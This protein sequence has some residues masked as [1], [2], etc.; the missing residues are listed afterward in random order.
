MSDNRVAK[1]YGSMSRRPP[2][3]STALLRIRCNCLKSLVI[4]ESV[5][6][7]SVGGTCSVLDLGC[8]KGGDLSK[9][10]KLRNVTR[11]LGVDVS[12]D[13]VEEANRRLRRRSRSVQRAF[14]FE[15]CDLNVPGEGNSRSVNPFC[16][17]GRRYDLVVCNFAVHYFFSATLFQQVASVLHKN[18]LFVFIKI[19]ADRLRKICSKLGTRGVFQT[20]VVRIEAKQS[21]YDFFLKGSVNCTEPYV[22][23]T[24][25]DRFCRASRL[26]RVRTETFD[27]IWSRLVE[28]NSDPSPQLSWLRNY[29]R[30]CDEITA[31][32]SSP[33]AKIQADVFSLY[34]VVTLTKPS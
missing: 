16:E 28:R 32:I 24:D 34:D 18:G 22:E 4:S 17:R 27:D 8:G 7:A 2:E 13:C 11:Y 5:S 20:E 31:Q 15:V 12:P 14:R 9:F 30:Q 19:N 3:R 33:R 25:I 6:S 29:L 10:A 1:H 26:R 21:N 23:D